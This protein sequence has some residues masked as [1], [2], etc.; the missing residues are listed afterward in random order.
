LQQSGLTEVTTDQSQPPPTTTDHNDQPPLA[1]NYS[2]IDSLSL[3]I[4]KMSGKPTKRSGPNA[5]PNP[6]PTPTA[7]RNL[8]PTGTG[9]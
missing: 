2:L 7:I 5:N 3:C 1:T 9:C 6:N 4:I 8:L